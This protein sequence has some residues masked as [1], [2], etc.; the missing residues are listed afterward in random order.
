[1]SISAYNLDLVDVISYQGNDVR[2][3]YL[4]TELIWEKR[5]STC[6]STEDE[7]CLLTEDND[8][9]LMEAFINIISVEEMPL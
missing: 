4:D 2:K 6:I 9:I 3:L 8:P 7:A 5:I 1:M